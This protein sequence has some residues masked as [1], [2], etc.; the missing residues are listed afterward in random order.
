M[1]RMH[2]FDIPEPSE[3]PSGWSAHT[4]G[5][6]WRWALS[7]DQI[8]ELVRAAEAVDASDPAVVAGLHHSPPPLPGLT[9]QLDQMTTNL[10]NGQGFELV[11]G[12]P[13]DEIGAS[14]ATAC[15]LVVSA[16]LGS[17]R[18]QNANGDLVGHVRNVGLASTDPN[19]RVYQTSERQ[20][21]HTDSTDVVGLLALSK[22]AEGGQSLVIS[23][24][25]VYHAMVDRHGDLVNELFAPVATDRRGET[26]SGSDPWFTIPVFT[27]WD[28]RLTVRYQRQYIDSAE[29]FD[30]APR[31][32]TRQVEAL[33]A[34]DDVCNDRSLQ[35]RMELEVGDMQ[36]VH[37]HSI[38]HDR[39][40][41]VDNP[42]RPRHL[43]RTW[44]SVTGD[45]HLHPVFA[46]RFGTITPGNRGGILT[47]PIPAPPVDGDGG[48][49]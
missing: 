44:M 26:P 40:A 30:R 7:S 47:P 5:N 37:N 48:S 24:N 19:V 18:R 11:S 6:E 29:R 9:D 22:A 35:A 36:F 2:D 20:T 49:K 32:S 17:L 14:Q 13:V 33:D 12:V 43:I 27:W 28:N 4:V 31:L 23:A 39:T 41:F 16:H 34:F 3:V 25:A 42:E 15:M 8:D 21:F 1:D 38:L 46:Q 45:R 10:L